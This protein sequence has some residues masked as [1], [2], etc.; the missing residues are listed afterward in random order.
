[1]SLWC[2]L[3]SV[4]S[5]YSADID[6][7][8][9]SEIF[10]TM[11]RPTSETQ[12]LPNHLDG[13]ASSNSTLNAFLGGKPKTWMTAGTN[14]SRSTPR[15]PTRSSS[16]STAA[17]QRKC[18]LANHASTMTLFPKLTCSSSAATVLPSP[19]PSDEPSPI[20]PPT[21]SP[22]AEVSP[23][24]PMYQA[25]QQ[26]PQQQPVN[27]D[28]RPSA[29][30]PQIRNQENQSPVTIQN[31]QTLQN[32]QNVQNAAQAQHQQKRKRSAM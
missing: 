31:V 1:M 14:T 7:K 22:A 11:R 16:A 18:V 6:R 10:E 20:Q 32:F 30:S 21:E 19:A 4:S 9:G 15:D 23:S 5:D 3:F 29:G 25:A 2:G 24:E 12:P 27:H 8:C 28:R 26:P 13:L 17:F